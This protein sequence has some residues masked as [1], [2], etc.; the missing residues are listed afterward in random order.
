MF[1]LKLISIRFGIISMEVKYLQNIGANCFLFIY[2]QYSEIFA[3]LS[4]KIKEKQQ[5]FFKETNVVLT[6]FLR[7]LFLLLNPADQ[8]GSGKS[9]K[10]HQR[11]L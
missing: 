4:L 7:S 11:S 2:F 9:Q 6:L 3:S 10:H 8:E 5:V 1:V